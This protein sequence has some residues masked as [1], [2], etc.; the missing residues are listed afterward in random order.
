MA[1]EWDTEKA[2]SNLAKHRVSFDEASTV[3]GDPIGKIVSDPRHSITEQRYVLLGYSERQ[4][5][6]AV[7]FA[8]RGEQIRIISARCATRHER[9]QYEEE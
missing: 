3:F 2:K 8:E 9:R 6:L 7:M 1:Y 5:I 4:R